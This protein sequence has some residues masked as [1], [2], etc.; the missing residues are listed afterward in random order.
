MFPSTERIYLENRTNALL[1]QLGAR[2]GGVENKMNV[3]EERMCAA[4]EIVFS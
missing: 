4:E 3:V 2:L 1:R